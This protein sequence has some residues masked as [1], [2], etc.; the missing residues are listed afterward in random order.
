MTIS[1]LLSTLL[2]LP[3]A[4]GVTHWLLGGLHL[5]SS[6]GTEWVTQQ[7]MK[8]ALQII[9]ILL[10]LPESIKQSIKQSMG[11]Q[12]LQY[13]WW[14]EKSGKAQWAKLKP[15]IQGLMTWGQGFV[16]KN[17]VYSTSQGCYNTN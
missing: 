3:E 2:S 6:A 9:T 10:E 17:V 8:I 4:T 7:N 16:L 12:A 5:S 14:W 13:T 15:Q 1:L 11:M